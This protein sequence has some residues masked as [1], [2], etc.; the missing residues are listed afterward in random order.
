MD[1]VAELVEH[2]SELSVLQESWLG[3]GWFGETAD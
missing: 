3:K 2:C 1:C